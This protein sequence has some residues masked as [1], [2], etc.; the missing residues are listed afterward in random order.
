MCVCVRARAR[1]HA[2]GAT[3]WPTIQ[4]NVQASKTTHALTPAEL[5]AMAVWLGGFMLEAL[6]DY[7]KTLFRAN[8]AN[9]GKFI[10]SGLWARCRHPNYCGEIV[11]WTGVGLEMCVCVCVSI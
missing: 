7:E 4:V 8:P 3:L 9:A 5:A 2:R 11:A 6:A 10:C 1:T